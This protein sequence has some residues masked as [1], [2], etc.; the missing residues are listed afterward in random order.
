MEIPSRSNT[1][2][3][4]NNAFSLRRLL[5][6]NFRMTLRTGE[7]PAADLH[8]KLT[9]KVSPTLRNRHPIA[10]I[11]TRI[12]SQFGA[13]RSS[14]PQDA[15]I[16]LRLPA[17]TPAA[18]HRVAPFKRRVALRLGREAVPREAARKRGTPH[19]RR[20]RLPRP[21]PRSGVQRG[22]RGLWLRRGPRQTPTPRTSC[23]LYS[24]E[25][26]GTRHHLL[27]LPPPGS[28]A[29]LWA[30]GESGCGVIQCL[31]EQFQPVGVWQSLKEVGKAAS[32]SGR[33]RTSSTAGSSS[34]QQQSQSVQPPPPH[35]RCGEGSQG[36][37]TS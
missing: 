22:A 13:H 9:I 17:P 29:Q 14:R 19:R 10:G 16:R 30:P 31:P 11:H 35:C 37:M 24:R 32:L 12:C 21:A 26:S 6:S 27:K 4:P 8:W 7:R 3:T 34:Q 28:S 18:T 36:T 2:G 23:L 5:Q 25:F 33:A 15:H 1:L 20:A